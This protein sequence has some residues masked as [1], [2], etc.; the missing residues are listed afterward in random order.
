L[1]LEQQQHHQLF[2]AAHIKLSASW[3]CFFL[4]GKT[5]KGN[6]TQEEQQQQEQ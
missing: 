5:R 6:T 1:Q 2:A 4:S 3:G